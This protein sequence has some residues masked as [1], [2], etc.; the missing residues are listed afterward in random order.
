M[1]LLHIWWRILAQDNIQMVSV[2]SLLDE[3]KKRN[4]NDF[5]IY[6]THPYETN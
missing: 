3:N 5:L 4:R 2:R 1:E 6:F